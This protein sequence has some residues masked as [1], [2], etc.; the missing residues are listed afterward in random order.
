[1]TVYNAYNR[2]VDKLMGA[3]LRKEEDPTPVRFRSLVFKA[4]RD[5]MPLLH[6]L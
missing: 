2:H 6:P 4:S 5:S 1:M 3:L